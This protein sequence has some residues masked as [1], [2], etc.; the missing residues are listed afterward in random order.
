MNGNRFLAAC[1]RQH[2]DST[3]VWLMRQAGRYLPQYREVRARAGGFLDLCKTP[4]LACEVTLQPVDALGVDAAIIFADILLPVEAMGVSLKFS[5]GEGPVLEPVRN[6]SDLKALHVPDPVAET[7]FVMDAI[8]L[9]VHELSNDIPLIGFSGA[10][11]TLATYVVEGGTSRR[12]R[13]VLGW[14]YSDPEG[15]RSLLD[16]LAETVILYLKAQVDAG[17]AAVQLFDTWAGILSR[18]N[19]REFALK[20]TARIVEALS[21]LNVPIILYAKGSSP[22]LEEMVATGADVLSVDW[23]ISLAEASARTRGAVSLQGNLDPITLFAPENVLEQEVRRIL[24][25][26]PATGH[27]FNL[28]HGIQPDT[29][30]E[31]AAAL[32]RLVHDLSRRE[33]MVYKSDNR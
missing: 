17:V 30:V 27:V 12:F 21:G 3:P 24:A 7:G 33:P 1:R 2:V 14:M 11:F 9:A 19:Y 31:K 25:E 13:H 16:L 29:P 20:P 23:R 5:E 6:L 10:P 4:E 32:V 22:F 15:F 28:G 18:R 26:A 8:G